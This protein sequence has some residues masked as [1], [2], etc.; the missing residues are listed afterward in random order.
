MKKRIIEISEETYVKLKDQ[1][2]EDILEINKLDDLV[3][4]AFFFRTVTYHLVGMVKSRLKGTSFL[5]LSN[6]SWIAD[7]GR[8]MN[9]IKAGKLAEVEPV[10][11]AFI[12][13]DTLFCSYLHLNLE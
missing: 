7:S 1:L 12:N 3:G 4:R 10:G 11:E 9:A 8:F 2:G 13:L 5:S 6:A